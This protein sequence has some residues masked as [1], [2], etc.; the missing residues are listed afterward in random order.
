M[1]ADPAQ[2]DLAVAMTAC[3]SLRTIDRAIASVSGLARRVVVVDSGSSDGTDERCRELGAEVIHR[4]WPGYV[5]QAQYA[6][7]QCAGHAWVLLLDS[8]EALE[9]NLRESVRGVVES[10]NGANDA[11]E[12]NRKIWWRDGWLNH[13]FQPEWR[14]RLF[15]GGRASVVGS[16]PHYRVCVSGPVGRLPGDLRHESWSDLP[17]MCRRYVQYARLSAESGARGGRA[18]DLLVSPPAAF[19]KQLVIKRGFLDGRRGVVAAG[20]AA[21]GTL[22]KHL[23]IAGRRAGLAAAVEAGVEADDSE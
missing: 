6:I 14:L 17:D 3:N 10:S 13:A 2:S 18:V 4:P 15:R 20:G 5:R 16:D 19:V 11:W 21:M 12:L 9:P 8:D 22:V 1:P 23:F 7:D